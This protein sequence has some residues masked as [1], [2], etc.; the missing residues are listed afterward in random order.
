[1]KRQLPRRAKDKALTSLA[2]KRNDILASGLFQIAS[3]YTL[4]ENNAL[5]RAKRL[6]IRQQCSHY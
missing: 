4:Q 6:K 1:M 2:S 3:R 5:L